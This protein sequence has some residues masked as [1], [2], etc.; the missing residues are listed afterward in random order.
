MASGKAVVEAG[1]RFV[2]W[3]ERNAAAVARLSHQAAAG[4][5]GGNGGGS[6][7]RAGTGGAG[8]C[9]GAEVGKA[10]WLVGARCGHVGHVETVS[11]GAPSSVGT[12]FPRQLPASSD[13][14]RVSMSAATPLILLIGNGGRGVEKR[15]LTT[16]TTTTTSDH[17]VPTNLRHN[18]KRSH[19][20]CRR[21]S[22]DSAV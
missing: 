10:K 5:E 19:I 20:F 16:T 4:A 9:V 21:G 18:R 7:Q 12:V 22:N 14:R 3:G 6:G 8:T 11:V 15:A 17:S 2:H 13:G 1:R